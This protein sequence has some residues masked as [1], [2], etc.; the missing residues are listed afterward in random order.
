[1]AEL[2]LRGGPE[3][4][5]TLDV[6]EWPQHTVESIE[7]VVDCLESNAW[8]RVS[9]DAKWVDQFEDRYAE[10]HDADHAIAV[11]NGTVAIELA[12]KMCDV[13]PGDEVLVPPYTFIA[14]ASAVTSVG[15]VP[16]FVD[17]DPKTYN[18]DPESVAERVTD[19]TVGLVGVHFA[20]YPMDFDELLPVVDEHD[21]FLIE[22]AA[23]AQGTEW[24]GEKVGTVGD[25]GTFSFQE[26]KALPGGE[27]GIVVTDDD[28]RAEQGHLLHN[29]GRQ[30][31]EAYRHYALSSN[32]R[33]SEVQGALLCAQLEKLTE[34][35]ERRR[36]NHDRLV[37][38]LS[39]IDGIETKPADDRITARGFCLFNFR[40]REAAFDGL[41]K[42]RFIEALN[43]EGVPVSEGY[44]R[45]LYRQ[46]AFSREHVE[47]HVPRSVDVPAYN[48]LSLP[49]VQEVTRTNVTLPHEVLLADSDGIDAIPR[50]IEKIKDQVDR[51]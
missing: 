21:L 28:V 30:G 7:N 18:V 48:N 36:R 29:I 24:N 44:G 50:A 19:D 40:Y 22:D 2:A 12:L 17:V 9:E 49:G 14:T 27:G 39:A 46:P 51:L 42:E 5:S 20:G 1:M 23:H 4:A 38:G 32:K 47:S 8:C 6:P 26:S 41:S 25:V 31:G 35:N 3:A 34:E 45:P 10:Y 16:R 43:A 11:A 33:L 13:R 37:K 15:A